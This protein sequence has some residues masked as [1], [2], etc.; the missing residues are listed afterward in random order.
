MN[1]LLNDIFKD[2]ITDVKESEYFP[3]IKTVLIGAGVLL[4]IGLSGY[5]FKIFSFTVSNY[6][7]L[8]YIIKN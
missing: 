6:K 5:V 7:K 1:P 2:K 8:K 4:A 3:V